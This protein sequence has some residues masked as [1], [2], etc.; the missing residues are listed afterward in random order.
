MANESK[1]EW[2]QKYE[3]GNPGK[4]LDTNCEDIAQGNKSREVKLEK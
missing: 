4:D 3:R 2:E 1:V